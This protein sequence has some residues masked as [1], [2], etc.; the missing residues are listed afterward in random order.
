VELPPADVIGRLVADYRALIETSLGDPVGSG[1]GPAEALAAAVLEPVARHVPA[2]TPVIVVPDGPLHAVNLEALPVGSPRRYWIEH[3]IVSNA[4]S[5]A[6]AA[7]E[8]APRRRGRP[9]LLLGGVP[10]AT[11]LPALR[12]AGT[13][14]EAIA[15]AFPTAATEIHRGPGATA[16]AYEAS[17]PGQFSMIHFAA[18]ATVTCASPLDSSIE[19]SPAAGRLP[20][21]AREVA[22]QPLGA[23]LVTISAC[24]G[25]GG[26]AY[27]GEG[28]VGFAWAFLRAGARRVIAGLWDVDD[29][30]TARL[31]GTLYERLAAGDAPAVALRQ[32]KLDLI[33]SGGNFAKP[34]YWAPFQL[35]RAAR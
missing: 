13:E 19:L 3:V 25:A 27:S 4:P 21:Y 2:G 35:Y 22:A 32:A 5:L 12:F 15:R 29:Q 1:A 24:R 31:M 14:L 9:S 16:N 7:A 20:L 17:Q 23:D 18:H 34:Y 6:V 11:D 30:S 26:R 28:L 10:V 33:R 8:A